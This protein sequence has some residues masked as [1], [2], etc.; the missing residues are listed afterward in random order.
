M[1]NILILKS[2]KTII[3]KDSIIS[4][5]SKPGNKITATNF[6]RAE[7]RGDIESVYVED[8]KYR[9][10]KSDITCGS[11]YD[12]IRMITGLSKVNTSMIKVGEQTLEEVLKIGKK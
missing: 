12:A 6:E 1:A 4:L 11:I 10:I 3:K 8:K 2:R 9:L 7:K 5:K